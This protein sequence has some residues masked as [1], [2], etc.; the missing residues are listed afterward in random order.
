MNIMQ[1][2]RKWFGG[3]THP[4]DCSIACPYSERIEQ[5]EHLMAQQ[6]NELEQRYIEERRQKEE[7]KEEM[8]R[9]VQRIERRMIDV[10][11]EN[12]S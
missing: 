8:L 1:I 11:L 7:E 4:H 9:R 6:Q 10:N 3:S 5:C 2:V 12:Q